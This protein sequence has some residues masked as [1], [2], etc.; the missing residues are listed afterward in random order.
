MIEKMTSKNLTV[1][2]KLNNPRINKIPQS[3]KS[4]PYRP[5]KGHKI[6]IPII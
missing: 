2:S 3:I 6:Q 4:E 5:R 1:K